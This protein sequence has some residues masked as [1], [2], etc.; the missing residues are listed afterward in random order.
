MV[1]HRFADVLVSG[2]VE[3]QMDVTV[4]GEEPRPAYDRVALTSYLTGT[5][6]DELSL[7]AHGDRVSLRL[8]ERVVSIDRDRH[9]VVTDCESEIGY[10]DLVLATG[11]VP[12]VPPVPGRELPGVF[13]Y[14][15][16]D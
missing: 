8:G 11:S 7:P 5:T 15:T 13:T 4:V 12:F 10:D 14:R 6:A 16:I 1:A 9:V 3:R 2:D